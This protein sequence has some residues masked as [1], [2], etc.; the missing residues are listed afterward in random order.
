[1]NMR[2][3]EIIGTQDH[4][5]THVLYKWMETFYQDCISLQETETLSKVHQGTKLAWL[6]GA[7]SKIGRTKQ[8]SVSGD[9]C[10]SFQVLDDY[11]A[12]ME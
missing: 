7:Q 2:A 8:G 6:F 10:I 4:Q 5:D 9:M 3:V 11:G 12:E 1:M